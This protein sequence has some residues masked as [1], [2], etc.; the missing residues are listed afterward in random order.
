MRGKEGGRRGG[1]EGGRKEGERGGRGMERRRGEGNKEKWVFVNV[2]VT[3][4]AKDVYTQHTYIHTYTPH[5]FTAY[6]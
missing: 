2:C 3:Y 4:V 5:I 1:R 6:L